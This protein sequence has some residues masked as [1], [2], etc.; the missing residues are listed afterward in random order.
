MRSRFTSPSISNVDPDQVPEH[1]KTEN[2]EAI[3]IEI[4]NQD[5]GIR[6]FLCP[7]QFVSIENRD[8]K[9]HERYWT[10]GCYIKTLID[11]D[12]V[13]VTSKTHFEDN[14]TK[15]DMSMFYGLDIS[16]SMI[17]QITGKQFDD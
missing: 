1:L 9:T 2:L 5:I 6:V 16:R 11:G 4:D 3:S 8:K 7:A 10:V 15:E 13:L 12:I 17:E 14:D